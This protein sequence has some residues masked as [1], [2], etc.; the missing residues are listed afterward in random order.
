[1]LLYEKIIK[2][3]LKKKIKPIL[4]GSLDDK[5]I[6]SQLSTISKEILNLCTLTSIGQIFFLAKHSFFQ[7]E[8]TQGPCISLRGQIK[9]T[10][11]FTKF[12][13]PKLCKPTGKDVEILKYPNNNSDFFLTIKKILTKVYM[14]LLIVDID[15]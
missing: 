10:C 13:D 2:F 14:I 15:F 7:L 1:M 3:L 5:K 11:F 9:N 12:S 4:I 6:C 8:M